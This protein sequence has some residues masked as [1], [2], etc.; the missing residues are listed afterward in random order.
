MNSDHM[1]EGGVLKDVVC[2]MD[3]SSDSPHHYRY[4]GENF[5]FCCEN[6]LNK[7]KGDPEHYLKKEPAESG[8]LKDVVCGMDVS[9]DSPHHYRYKGE[10]FYFCGEHCLNKFK[11]D[12]EHYLK[13][14][15]APETA[16]GGAVLYTCPMDPE[17]S[18]PTMGICPKCGMAL[19]PSGVPLP[20]TTTDYVCP[21]HPE[22][23][24][25]HPGSCPKCGMALEP[26]TVTAEEENPE[27]I[28]M[29]RRF[30]IST[31]LAVPVFLLAMTGDLLPALLPEWLS[32]RD[33]QWI[34]FILATPVVLWGGWPFFVRGWQSIRTW[35]LNMFTLIGLGVSV[36]WTYSVVALLFPQIFPPAMR[37]K[38]GMVHVY[39]ESAAM[40]TVLVLLGQVLELRARSRTN[41]AIRM[42]LA[43]APNTARIVRDDGTEEDIPLEQVKLGDVLRLRPGE[44]VPVDGTVIE[45]KSSVDESMVTGESIPIEKVS[46]DTLI[47]A[48]TNGTGSLLMR[49]EKV[50]AD[51]LLSQIVNMVAEAQRSRAPIQKLAD[52]VSGYFVPV[53]VIAAVVAFVVWVFWGPEPRL[54]HAIV[55][56][57]AVLIIA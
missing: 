16:A 17:I 29:T 11:G 34:S 48:T 39:F 12:P 6:C 3:V 13:K 26:R 28:D 49:A 20:A 57:V 45:G 44:N 42:L 4:E 2:G 10:D 8:A 35:N 7:F 54:A 23:T 24:Q 50:G 14:E 31:I 43:L 36:A 37:M 18:Q 1:K 40:I 22:V 51:T 33:V 55:N 30:W 47:G 19:E 38:G 56:A 52:V 27:L 21:M 25:D 5:Y 15:P 53:V 9:S 32:L 41:T 46:G